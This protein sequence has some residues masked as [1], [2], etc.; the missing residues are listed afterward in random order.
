MP[1]PLLS[2]ILFL[3]P[4][5]TFTNSVSSSPR[6]RPRTHIF[7]NKH[8]P[9]T[10]WRRKPQTRPPFSK[11]LLLQNQNPHPRV[12]THIVSMRPT[13]SNSVTTDKQMQPVEGC[14]G[15]R[16][17]EGHSRFLLQSADLFK[18]HNLQKNL[19]ELLMSEWR[20]ILTNSVT[21]SELLVLMV[22]R[23]CWGLSQGAK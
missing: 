9:E 14:A 16:A 8:Q 7:L 3:Q 17:A 12:T 5:K 11:T 10:H 23:W 1:A 6:N 20:E 19:A 13:G 4:L 15:V 22:V 21:L 2:F 18:P